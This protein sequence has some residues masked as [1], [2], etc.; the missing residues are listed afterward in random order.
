M[1]WRLQ[2]YRLPCPVRPC[3]GSPKRGSPTGPPDQAPPAASSLRNWYRQPPTPASSTCR[4]QQR[5]ARDPR[6]GRLRCQRP[7]PSQSKSFSRRGPSSILPRRATLCWRASKPKT[8]GGEQEVKTPARGGHPEQATHTTGTSHS[9]VTH[10][11]IGQ[12]GESETPRGTHSIGTPGLLRMISRPKSSHPAE[13][14]MYSRSRR[15]AK[16]CP[17]VHQ[18]DGT[19]PTPLRGSP[20]E[21]SETG[22]L[23]AGQPQRSTV[24]RDLTKPKNISTCFISDHL[25][26]SFFIISSYNS[27]I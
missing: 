2:G 26:L 22:K 21:R 27:T 17:A 7:K 19:V 1:Q 4:P 3:W 15:P 23:A 10:S 13:T 9:V 18:G 5:W 8:S 6:R 12:V 24:T 25:C 20:C 16:S 11:T 14:P